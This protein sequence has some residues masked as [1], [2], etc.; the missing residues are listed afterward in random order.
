MLSRM[1]SGISSS[2]SPDRPPRPEP[3]RCAR[4]R[5][6]ARTASSRR[7]AVMPQPTCRARMNQR[8][9]GRSSS[10]RSSR[11]LTLS[12]PVAWRSR[13][14]SSTRCAPL[15]N[16]NSRRS[17][18]ARGCRAARPAGAAGGS[19]PA[20]MSPSATSVTSPT[21]KPAP[22]PDPLAA[23]RGGE[24]EGAR[25]VGSSRQICRTP[26]PPSGSVVAQAQRA[27]R[28]ADAAGRSPSTSQPAAGAG[29]VL[30]PERGRARGD[31]REGRGRTA[32]A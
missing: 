31:G 23:D 15:G 11:P 30:G 25:S 7:R 21:R 24:A 8:I 9:P 1:P 22:P 12:S 6:R 20:A 27:A 5:R 18:P 17:A 4:G 10:A 32:R 14:A 3:G 26:T 16:L 2:S 29:T 19:R 13:I 28:D